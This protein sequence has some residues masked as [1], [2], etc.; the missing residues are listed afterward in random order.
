[1]AH[2][3]KLAIRGIRSF[4]DKQISVIEFF[5]PVT[6]IV[7]HN[8]SGKTTIIECLKYATTGEQPPNT[9]GGAFVHDPKMA[10]EKEVKA[11]VKL[12]FHAANGTR[13]LAVRN[14]SVTVKKT[15]GLTMKT[16]ESILA[17]ADSNAEQGGKRGVISTKCAEM[18]AE[19]PQLLGVS[20]A[21]LE[22]VIFCHQEDSYWPLAEPSILKKKF[23]DIFE[24]TRYTKALDNIKTLR[25]E[26]VADLKAEKE[27]LLGLSREKQHLDKLRGRIKDATA[28]IAAKEVEYDTSKEEFDRVAEENRKFYEY[29][30]KFREIYKDVENLEQMKTRLQRDLQEARDGNFEELPETDEELKARL[31]QFDQFIEA[32]KQTLRREE[33]RKQDIEDEIAGFRDQLSDLL[34]AKGQLS[35]E[36][37][38]QRQRINER[39]QTIR[40]ISKQHSMHVAGSQSLERDQVVEFMSRI[41]EIQR[42]HR[43]EFE[44]LQGDLKEKR[45]EYNAKVRKLEN[46][47]QKYKTQRQTYRDTLQERQNSIRRFDRELEGQ[48]TLRSELQSTQE[49]L[50]EKRN[51]VEKFKKDIASKNFDEQLQEKTE[52]S[53]KLEEDREAL[54][55]ENQMLNMQAESRAN[56]NLKRTE[57]KTK[58]QEIQ[59][60]IKTISFKFEELAGRQ[61]KPDSIEEE[62]DTLLRTKEDE[63][64]EADRDA[65]A[66]NSSLH[67]L[68]A[69]INNLKTQI[70]A[71]QREVKEHEGKIR[72]AIGGADGDGFTKLED[73]IKESTT[74][75][76]SLKK[77]NDVARDQLIN[78]EIPAL[79][80][81]L[82]EKEEQRP[83]LVSQAE[84]LAD[85]LD[86]LK[87]LVKST[88]SLKQQ[89]GTLTTLRKSIEK[90]ESEISD[91]ETELSTTGSTKTVADV[92]NEL[93]KISMEIRAI[94]KERQSV[95][96][97]RDRLQNAL[98]SFE[99]KC[100]QLELEEQKLLSKSNEMNATSERLEQAKKEVTSLSA[101]IKE[102]DTKIGDAQGPIQI[103]ENE[104]QQHE[105]DFNAKINQCQSHLQ[106]LNMSVDKLQNMNKAIERYVKERKSR[107]LDECVLKIRQCEEELGATEKTLEDCRDKVKAIER[108]ISESGASNTNLRENLRVRKLQKEIVEIQ[109]KI[110]QF[111]V[112]EAARAKRNF[113]T[114]WAKRHGE[115]NRLKEGYTL[116]AGELSSMRTQLKDLEGDLKEFKDTNKNYTEQ[117]IRV[118][119]S[120]MANN[121]LEKYAKA[122]DNAIMKYHGLKMEEVNDTMKHL[123]N[124]TYQGTDIDGIKIKSDVEGGASKRSY[125]YRVVMTKDQVEMDM[126]GR[127]SAGQKMLASIIIRL[128]LSDSFGQNCGILALDEPTNALDTENIDALAE[129]LVDIIN[130]RK[131]HSNFQL[132]IITHDEG[133]LRKLGQADVMEYYWRVSRDARQKSVIERQ[134]FR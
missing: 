106:D 7:G 124:K 23:D 125:N 75:L 103:L 3:N 10:N 29:N 22:N 98:R 12:R 100:H 80:A 25:K 45:E 57:V 72:D 5:S 28:N 74:E 64:E 128:A 114:Q 123:W 20:K 73:A 9:R 34:S 81:E 63:Q 61:P 60:T 93:N 92:Q 30:S 62:I 11:Q 33:R 113:E 69:A 55:K 21:V 13:M 78:K 121:D 131:S 68:E 94:E 102:L 58:T 127:C 15:A 105:D 67:S 14:L 35:A 66:A 52:Q 26:R 86:E 48:T 44:K 77:P 4:D 36:A 41:V 46:E 18:D 133:F 40:D 39:E 112:E 85:K 108:E 107:D 49:E 97:D 82:A 134:R 104:L 6:V 96:A 118:K 117:L 1:M 88:L 119:V 50:E 109:A 90:T 130:E 24:A 16:L 122:L 32:Q 54:L 111:D 89:V 120:D 56:L 2:L 87:Q 71:K 84:E 101:Q 83:K 95:L 126:R 129:S 17:L 59:S 31:D 37:E 99:S 43:T 42:R 51:R 70:S 76:E 65:T 38:Q 19:I 110:D 47:S 116:L 53:R 79:K 27:R 8:G 132:I 115:E 91:L